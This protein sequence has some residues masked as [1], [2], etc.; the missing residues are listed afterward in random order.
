MYVPLFV[1]LGFS[2]ACLC[3]ALAAMNHCPIEVVGGVANENRG[4]KVID[5]ISRHSELRRKY[6]IEA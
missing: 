3:I 4:P 6:F 2:F 5:N 1:Q